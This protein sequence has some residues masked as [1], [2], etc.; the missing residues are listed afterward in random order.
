MQFAILKEP[1]A[2]PNRQQIKNIDLSR[3]KIGD[4]L[5]A[6]IID[7]RPSGRTIL[8]FDSFKA[9]SVKISGGRIGDILWFEVS[10]MED[11]AG[12]PSPSPLKSTPSDLPRPPE[13]YAKR[14]NK[15]AGRCARLQSLSLKPVLSSG[16]MKTDSLPLSKAVS[17]T[18]PLSLSVPIQETGTAQAF[19]MI[20][21][22]LRRLKSQHSSTRR[23]GQGPMQAMAKAGILNDSVPPASHDRPGSVARPERADP[24]NEEPS[25][26]HF[27][28]VYL[29]HSP[30]KIKVKGF[31]TS[32]HKDSA[33]PIFKAVFCLAL[34]NTGPVRADIQIGLERIEVFF[35]VENEDCRSR[36]VEALPG[37]IAALSPLSKHCCSQVKVSPSRIQEFIN[38]GVETQGKGRFDIRV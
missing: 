9:V 19:Q 13:A 1:L 25:D 35:Y 14:A 17:Q 12:S 28:T 23:S 3:L 15:G 26:L 38:E 31:P 27:G 16:V 6:R 33:P 36:F 20:S 29:G 8:Q 5:E 30:V 37:L 2:I 18:F 32:H 7:I 22:W 24:M 10:P 4:R 34:E 11:K 21:S